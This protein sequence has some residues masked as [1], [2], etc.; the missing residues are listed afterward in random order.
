MQGRWAVHAQTL[1]GPLPGPGCVHSCAYC[2][3][4]QAAPKGH[5]HVPGCLILLHRSECAIMC[6]QMSRRGHAWT[7]A[8]VITQSHS[9]VPRLFT[10]FSYVRHASSGTYR[11]TSNNIQQV[12]WLPESCRTLLILGHL[13][14]TS[15]QATRISD[16]GHHTAWQVAPTNL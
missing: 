9:T 14:M 10:T 1:P 3:V 7:F 12:L 16:R 8:A 15:Q 4:P 13:S 5:M 6:L 2:V 11:V